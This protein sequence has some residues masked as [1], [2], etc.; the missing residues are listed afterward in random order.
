MLRFLKI[1]ISVA[2][3]LAVQ[4]YAQTSTRVDPLPRIDGYGPYKFGMSIEQAKKARPDAKKTDCDYV[5]AAYC[6]TLSTQLF[7]QDAIINALFNANTKRLSQ[8]NITFD[9]MKGKE[10]GC[11][12][13]VEEIAVHMIQRWGT[14]TRE[15][16]WAIHWESPYGGTVTFLRV[17]LDDDSGIVVVSYSDTLGL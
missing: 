6:L 11:K 7:G 5:G 9:R 17:C 13:L 15:D 14:F 16:G 3:L 4:T 10:K 12:K 1:A 8:I 2:L